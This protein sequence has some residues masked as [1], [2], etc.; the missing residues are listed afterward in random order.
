MARPHLFQIRYSGAFP[1]SAYC[2]EMPIKLQVQLSAAKKDSMA[3]LLL[4]QT[5]CS[6]LMWSDRYHLAPAFVRKLDIQQIAI[7]EFETWRSLVCLRNK[8]TSGLSTAQE[9]SSCSP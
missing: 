1:H 8:L 2:Q 7:R 9:Q 4:V 5:Y 3:A 6:L